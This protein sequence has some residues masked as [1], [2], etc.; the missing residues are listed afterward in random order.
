MKKPNN[1][2]I[3]ETCLIL[4]ALL[5]SVVVLSAIFMWVYTATQPKLPSFSS[6][7]VLSVSLVGQRTVFNCNKPTESGE[8][9]VYRVQFRQALVL[10][11]NEGKIK[12]DYALAR[13]HKPGDGEYPPKILQS[14]KQAVRVLYGGDYPACVG[15][16]SGQNPFIHIVRFEP[17]RQGAK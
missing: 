4:V 13:F 3:R 2:V 14:Q 9:T 15:G 17:L 12:T 6:A 16:E 7:E 1:K 11:L 5:G 8:W 10:S